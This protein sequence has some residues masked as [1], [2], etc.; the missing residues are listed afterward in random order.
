MTIVEAMKT[1]CL[2]RPGLTAI[3]WPDIRR[4]IPELRPPAHH[5]GG[6]APQRRY[7]GRAGAIRR[8]RSGPAL[9][10]GAAGAKTGDTV[11]VEWTYGLSNAV[12]VG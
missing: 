11:T 4:N 9:P 3:V 10:G 5:D 1:A 7:R 8:R 6:H 12:V 2:E